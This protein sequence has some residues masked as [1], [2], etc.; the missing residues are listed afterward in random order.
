MAGPGEYRCRRSPSINLRGRFGQRRISTKSA[1]IKSVIT[2]IRPIFSDL[3]IF[4][5]IF[6]PSFAAFFESRSLLVS[7]RKDPPFQQV[8]VR[9]SVPMSDLVR[10]F[11][12]LTNRNC[13]GYWPNSLSI[14]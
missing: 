10:G 4:L 7:R 2:A 6:S 14:D 5:F 8:P 1:R 12:L 9:A 11:G 3:G 13:L